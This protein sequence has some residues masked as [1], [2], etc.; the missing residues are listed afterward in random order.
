MVPI[1]AAIL[2]QL[3]GKGGYKWLTIPLLGLIAAY[4]VNGPWYLI[5]PAVW[6]TYSIGYG[7]P[8]GQVLDGRSPGVGMDG[9]PDYED[10]QIG[11]LKQYR[12]LSLFYRG[13]M[14]A[15]WLAPYGYWQISFAFGI[16]FLSPYLVHEW[17]SAELLRGLIAYTI[18]LILGL[19]L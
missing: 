12:G 11:I 1:V 14:P 5:V 4:L 2:D 16:G 7:S 9:R 10:W 8:W 18:L 15:L 6:L 3:R 13:A 19:V 17:D